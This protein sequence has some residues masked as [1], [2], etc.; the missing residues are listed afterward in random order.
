[1][2]KAAIVARTVKAATLFSAS[3]EL[4]L[5]CFLTPHELALALPFRGRQLNAHSPRFDL[6]G[7]R[8]ALFVA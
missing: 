2:S 1:M 6:C 4:A 8:G 3:D 5:V 7:E